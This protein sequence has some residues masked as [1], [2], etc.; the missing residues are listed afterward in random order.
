MKSS[1]FSKDNLKD[2][3]HNNKQTMNEME[4]CPVFIFLL[5]VLIK[6]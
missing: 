5:S 1:K 6:I 4:T 2:E 3:I